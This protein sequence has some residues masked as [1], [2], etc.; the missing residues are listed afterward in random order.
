MN[1]KRFADLGL[2]VLISEMDINLCGGHEESW[3]E[4]L[5]HDVVEACINQ[6]GCSAI[7]FW[8]VHDESSWLNGWDRSGCGW[9]ESPRPLLFD[10]N[11][12][13]KETYNQVMDALLG[14]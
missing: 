6:P 11:Y 4:A 12:S 7:S 13:K 2:E 5:Y 10:N 1:L 14:R 3:Q 9:G 8:G